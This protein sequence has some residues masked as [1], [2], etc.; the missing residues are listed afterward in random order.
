MTTPFTTL[1]TR[2]REMLRMPDL[3]FVMLPHPMMVRSAE[4]IDAIAQQVLA[5]VA[6][7]FVPRSGDAGDAE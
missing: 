4:E 3:P 2:R 5:D 1:A 7:T 6:R